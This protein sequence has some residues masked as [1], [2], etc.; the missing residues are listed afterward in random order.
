MIF[1]P[2]ETSW[3]YDFKGKFD[4]GRQSSAQRL[5]KGNTLIAFSNQGVFIEITSDGDI[6]WKYV[7]PFC[8]VGEGSEP[9]NQAGLR[10]AME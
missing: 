8:T 5:P 4:D 9:K 2:A 6:V 7:S 10:Q 3:S 1:G